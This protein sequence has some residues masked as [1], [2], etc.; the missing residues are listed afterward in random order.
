MANQRLDTSVLPIGWGTG[1]ESKTLG[2]SLLRQ[3]DR[4]FERLLHEYRMTK[5]QQRRPGDPFPKSRHLVLDERRQPALPLGW[6]WIRLERG[7]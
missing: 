1:W 6:V 2:S 3:D 7:A 5:E 4:T